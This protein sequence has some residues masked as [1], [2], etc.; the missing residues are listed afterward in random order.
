M[1]KLSLLLVLFTAFTLSAQEYYFTTYNF[2]VEPQN[3]ETVYNLF[4]AYYSKNK[5]AGVSVGLYE[6]HFNDPENNFS[7]SVV[8]GGSLENLGNMY[9]GGNDTWNLFLTKLNQHIKEGFSSAM[10]SRRAIHGDTSTPHPVQRYFLLHVA[11]MDKFTDAYNKRLTTINPAGR[12]SMMGTISAGRG[13]DGA[14][15]WV[16]NGFKDFKAAIGG[17]DALMTDAQKK[18][19]DAAWEESRANS[20]DVTLVRS[21]MRVLLK[22]W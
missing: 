22:S 5:P 14:N 7:H 17:V 19:M 16:I 9:S 12:L 15:V 10:G 6:N 8:F 11:E 21:G 1:K 13:P 3:V 20:G 2:T 4:D 18:T